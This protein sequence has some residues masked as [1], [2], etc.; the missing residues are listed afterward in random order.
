[1]KL[2]SFLLI[3]MLAKTNVLVCQAFH[4]DSIKSYIQHLS[5]KSFWIE[6]GYADELKIENEAGRLISIKTNKVV[7]GLLAKIANNEKTVVIHIIL[8]KI[9]EPE[10][11]RFEEVFTYAAKKDSILSVTYT[12]NHLSWTYSPTTGANSIAKSEINTIEAYWNE[13]IKRKRY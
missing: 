11:D 7:K 13:K 8:T 5:W 2:K 4:Q 1:M 12:Y 9:F 10:N 3:V 6:Q